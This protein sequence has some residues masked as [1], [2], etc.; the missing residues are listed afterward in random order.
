MLILNHVPPFSPTGVQ[1]W[2]DYIS[3][4][5]GVG[6]NEFSDCDKN[7]IDCNMLLK[8][9]QW[10]FLDCPHESF[11]VISTPLLLNYC[12]SPCNHTVWLLH[13]SVM[14]KK[15]LCPGY[16]IKAECPRNRIWSHLEVLAG[17]WG[18]LLLTTACPKAAPP[19]WI[20]SGLCSAIRDRT[21]LSSYL[22]NYLN[23][24]FVI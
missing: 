22:K 9:L 3:S 4:D 19:S 10:L 12:Y 16:C 15:T 7:A 6:N 17:G 8:S 11:C 14:H 1:A 5:R 23:S 18:T 13:N 20:S 24:I 21:L 2:K